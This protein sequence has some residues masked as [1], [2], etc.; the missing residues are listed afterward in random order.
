[1]ALVSVSDAR[2]GDGWVVRKRQMNDAAFV[3]RHGFECDGLSAVFDALSHPLGQIAEGRI[4]S[5]L[6]AR[7]VDEQ[8]HPFSDL[9]G[10]NEADQ[11]LQGPKSLSP[12]SNEQSRIVAVH[13]DDRAIHFLA[14]RLLESDG[15]GN[16]H[17]FDQVLQDFDSRAGHDGWQSN[18]CNADSRRLASDAQYTR[19][20]VINDVY[21]DLVALCV[22][23]L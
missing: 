11:E 6:I 10:A 17:S 8:V 15:C 21:F 14:V 16:T 19:L 9:L 22:E 5:L 13:S 2:C 4:P 7:Y 18:A 23:L 1:M 12:P 20:A 3:W